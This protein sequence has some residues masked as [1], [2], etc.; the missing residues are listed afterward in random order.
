VRALF[1]H[2]EA[3]WTGRARSF[4]DAARALTR[5]GYQAVFVCRSGT[6]VATLAARLG[7]SV[8]PIAAGGRTLGDAL[9]LRE[10]VLEHFVDVIYVQT[11]R[12]QLAASLASRLAERGSI[13]RRLE[14]GEALE[15]GTRA[16]WATFLNGAAYLF[17]ADGRVPHSPAPSGADRVTTE[18]G[19]DLDSVDRQLDGMA[20]R[21][22]RL[23]CVST[24]LATGRVTNVL[25]AAAMLMERHADVR[26]TMIGSVAADDNVKLH[27]AALGIGARLEWVGNAP[28]V[29]ASLADA[30]VCCVV[31]DGDDAAYGFLDAMSRR[32]PVLAERSPLAE[33]FVSD[34][35]H[36]V[37]LPALDPPEMAAAI[38][39]L[40]DQPERRTTMGNAARSRVERE[41]SERLMA[42]GF[43]HAGRL[44]RER[45]RWHA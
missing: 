37:L 9:R 34:G 44:A 18:L 22:G 5:R 15:T 25:R 28:G 31:A 23:A 39:E 3:S 19:I 7:L 16:R 6:E 4:A 27:A 38:A 42:A 26:L 36:G 32:V 12:E 24:S 17:T 43:E 10:V 14:A 29:E 1:F 41:F 11:E 45:S 20:T 2:S 21:P 8:V 40:L 30:Q 35:I 33:R 13:V